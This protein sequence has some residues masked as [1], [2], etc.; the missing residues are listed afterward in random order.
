MIAIQK[1]HHNFVED[2]LESLDPGRQDLMSLRVDAIA[3]RYNSIILPTHN[4]GIFKMFF[5]YDRETSEFA[6]NFPTPSR[7]PGQSS[8]VIGTFWLG[9]VWELENPRRIPGIVPIAI[10]PYLPVAR[11]VRLKL[12]QWNSRDGG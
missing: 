2:T 12:F 11:F 5:H 4:L 8:A 6:W 3:A 10:N 7:F 9:V 1:C